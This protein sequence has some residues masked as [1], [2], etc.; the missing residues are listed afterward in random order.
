MKEKMKTTSKHSK[1]GKLSLEKEDLRW[2]TNEQVADWR[3][4]RMQ[5]IKIADIGCGI[6]FQAMS[7]AKK[8]ERVIAVDIDA[9]KILAAKA[10]SNKLH[11]RNI[12]FVAGDILSAETI[13]KI[14]GCDAI[15]LDPERE[16]NEKERLADNMKPNINEF[17]KKCSN[18]TNNIA[19]EFP[20][21]IKSIPFDCE[22]EYASVDGKL[23]RLTLYFGDFKRC[24]ASAVVLPAK[25][26][27]QKVRSLRL[28]QA[29]TPLKYLYEA[30]PAVHKAGLLA[31]LE[32]V[33]GATF[34][35]EKKQAYFT[36]VELIKS[37]FF[38]NSYR[39]LDIVEFEQRKMIDA[40]NK[41][42]A[43]KVLIRYE[44]NPDEYWEER[45]SIEKHL[46]GTRQLVLF[47]FNGMSV[48]TENLN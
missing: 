20:P 31:E 26:V 24:E 40:L 47:N 30:D 33:S 12:E 8:C 43:C 28:G 6:G 48:I 17:L 23:N 46:T 35:Y 44:V 7:F 36:S 27:L 15:F 18:I 10:N 16:A 34:V 21:Q 4:D 19:I 11:F 37:P 39:V 22:T 14:E 5:C 9:Q 13:G 2:A 3:A 38:R 41:L 29:L 25:A 1:E 45:N 42:G 32:K